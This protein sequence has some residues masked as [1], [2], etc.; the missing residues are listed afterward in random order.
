VIGPGEHCRAVNQENYPITVGWGNVNYI[1]QPGQDTFLP[2]EAIINFFGDPRSVDKITH[3]ELANGQHAWIPDRATELRRLR[4]KW[5]AMNMSGG[6]DELNAP[7]VDV[8]TLL[9][10]WVPT[11]A[12]DPKGLKVIPMLSTTSDRMD[13]DATISRMQ[14]QLD[15]LIRAKSM[16]QLI[17][18]S[19]AESDIPVDDST[20]SI[21]EPP[22]I[23]ARAANDD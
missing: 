11:V 14:A 19:I 3:A 6:E 18:P 17:E 22:D 12:N 5:Q 7:H 9:G 2:A 4:V 15:T 16:E 13:L 10:D 20:V 21:E 8:Y 1:L 23:V